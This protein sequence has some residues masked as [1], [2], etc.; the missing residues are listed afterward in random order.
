MEKIYFCL[1]K[2]KNT[3]PRNFGDLELGKVHDPWEWLFTN[4]RKFSNVYLKSTYYT[5]GA[6]VNSAQIGKNGWQ[7][8]VKNI[9]KTKT[10][11]AQKSSDYAPSGQFIFSVFSNWIVKL[12]LSYVDFFS[13]LQLFQLLLK[14]NLLRAIKQLWI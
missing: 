9:K 7:K 6:I 5:C 14:L 2:R 10:N 12:L 1:K 8:N 13:S 11:F 3:F 4:L